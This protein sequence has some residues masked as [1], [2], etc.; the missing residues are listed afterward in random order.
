MT[1][2]QT[3]ALPI[4]LVFNLRGGFFQGLAESVH[5]RHGFYLPGDGETVVFAFSELARG[6]CKLLNYADVALRVYAAGNDGGQHR[7]ER[8]GSN[9]KIGQGEIGREA[10]FSTPCVCKTGRERYQHCQKYD[11]DKKNQRVRKDK[12]PVAQ[13]IHA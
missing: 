6:D 11:A 3:C 13:P 5:L 9:G 10:A 1:G 2:V 7:D 8:H 12:P 4:Y